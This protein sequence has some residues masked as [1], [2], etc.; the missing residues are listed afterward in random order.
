MG[1]LSIMWKSKIATKEAV[2]AT[3]DTANK[4]DMGN[5]RLPIQIY[6]EKP[7]LRLTS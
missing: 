1:E 4:V 6:P 7:T 5:K 2:K 3:K